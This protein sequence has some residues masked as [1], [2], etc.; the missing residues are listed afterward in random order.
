MGARDDL[1]FSTSI[2]GIDFMASQV[3]FTVEIPQNKE[4]INKR[5]ICCCWSL[6]YCSLYLLFFPPNQHCHH[7]K[8]P[9]DSLLIKNLDAQLSFYKP[10]MCGERY[11]LTQHFIVLCAIP[12]HWKTLHSHIKT[13]DLYEIYIYFHLS[14]YV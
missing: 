4:L 7:D 13:E 10:T 14:F 8:Y 3:S 5:K 12:E 6:G 2:W 9:S 11:S 1:L